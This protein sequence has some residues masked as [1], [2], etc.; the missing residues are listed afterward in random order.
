MSRILRALGALAILVVVLIGTGAGTAHASADTTAPQWQ[1]TVVPTEGADDQPI[2]IHTSGGCPQNAP[3]ILGRVYGK[4]FPAE[5]TNVIGNTDAGVSLEHGFVTAL[6][7][8]MREFM[9][10]QDAPVPLKGTYQLVVSCRKPEF[11]KS[12]GDYVVAIRFT[13]PHHWVQAAPV[14]TEPG[15]QA[16]DGSSDTGGDAGVDPGAPT[17]DGS[18]GASGEGTGDPSG[19]ASGGPSGGSSTGGSGGTSG[20]KSGDPAGTTSGEQGSDPGSTTTQADTVRSDGGLSREAW[21]TVIGGV[22]IALVTV[23]FFVRSRT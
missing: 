6:F 3:N 21:A 4:G 15:P 16:H 1:A 20:D 18:P 17:G 23:T 13:D 22:L 7:T 10:D 12:Y 11:E 5:G 2:E 8:T 19:G 9:F 14:S